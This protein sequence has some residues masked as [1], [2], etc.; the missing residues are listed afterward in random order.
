MLLLRTDK[1]P[2]GPE[3]L[4]ELKLDGYRAIGFKTGDKIHLRSRNDN[5]F[6]ARYPRIVKALAAMP[7]ENRTLRENRLASGRNDPEVAIGPR[8]TLKLLVGMVEWRT[9]R[10]LFGG[11]R[12]RSGFLR[13]LRPRRWRPIVVIVDRENRLHAGRWNWRISYLI[14]I[15]SKLFVMSPS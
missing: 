8:Y 4:T 14:L 11:F 9:H 15:A 10:R 5:D 2:E 1:L 12:T 3:W 6:N 7:D 13:R